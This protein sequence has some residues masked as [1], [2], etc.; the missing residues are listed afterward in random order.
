MSAL[1]NLA[2]EDKVRELACAHFECDPTLVMRGASF[3]EDL[4]ADSLDVIEFVLLLEEYF[5]LEIPD[6]DAEKIKTI[7][8]VIDYIKVR[9]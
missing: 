1:R 5:Q 2:V 9:T 4:K 8:E 3:E 6:E 7:G